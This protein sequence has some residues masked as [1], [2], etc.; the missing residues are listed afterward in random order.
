MPIA[1]YARVNCLLHAVRQRPPRLRLGRVGEHLVVDVGDVADERDPPEP[2]G[3]PA[4]QDVEAQRA[5]EVTDVR[6]GLHRRAAD[7][8]RDVGG[9]EWH[10]IAQR[11]RFRVVEPHGRCTGCH[12]TS[13]PAGHPANLAATRSRDGPPPPARVHVPGACLHARRRL[14]C[15]QLR[16]AEVSPNRPRA[17]CACRT[18][19]CFTSLPSSPRPCCSARP[20]RRR[21]SDPMTQRRSRSAPSVW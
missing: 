13:L 7:V 5:A 14:R 17:W 15:D 16:R 9:V 20:A 19:W 10:E 21:R 8:H 3:E 4:A 1:A 6:P 12:C 2:V 11:L 18:G